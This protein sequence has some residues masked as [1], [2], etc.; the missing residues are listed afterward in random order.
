MIP[1]MTASAAMPP[2]TCGKMVFH[3]IVDN[4]RR[5]FSFDGPGDPNG[6][7]LHHEMLFAAR[8]KEQFSRL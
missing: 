5:I 4:F 6:I 1:T 3:V 2:I 8:A 7:R